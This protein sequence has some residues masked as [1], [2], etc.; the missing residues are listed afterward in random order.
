MAS[1]KGKTFWVFIFKHPKMTTAGENPMLLL[2]SHAADAGIVTPYK[3]S[4]REFCT[5]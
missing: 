3:T 4:D 5:Y 2:S 1:F